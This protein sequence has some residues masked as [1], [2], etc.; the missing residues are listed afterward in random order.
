[1]YE[2]TRW[3]VLLAIAGFSVAILE[4]HVRGQNF[5]AN[6][7][8]FVVVILLGTL[9]QI[10]VRKEFRRAIEE[11]FKMDWTDTYP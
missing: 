11:M 6:V 9:F 4:F 5:G 8:A 2:I 7:C 10:T 1:M 3:A